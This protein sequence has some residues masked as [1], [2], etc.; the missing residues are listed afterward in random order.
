VRLIGVIDLKKGEAVH[1]RGG[2]RDTYAPVS[3]AAGTIVNGNAVTLARVY[4]DT[5][6]L[7]EIYVADLDAIETAAPPHDVVGDVAVLG[8]HVMLDA[9]V[10]T[11]ADI[12]RAGVAATA[13][14]VVGLETLES[15]DVLRKISQAEA[16][17]S[18]AFSLDLRNGRPVSS[19]SDIGRQSA[20]DVCRR[21][22]AA[23]VS[24]IIVLEL[25]RV[26][27]VAG[28]DVELLGRIRTA[29][30]AASILAG[31]GVRDLSDLRQLA[32]VGCDGAL[33]ATALHNG[34]LTPEDVG[35]A[36]RL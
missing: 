21:V 36:S 6:G 5:L 12:P 9:G 15:F 11:T 19:V 29:I 25:A 7:Q 23:G 3:E 1:A 13:T 2:L 30:P 16:G 34:R 27:R 31:G 28:P 4:R 32:K 24:T 26:G 35:A 10:R 22:V 8:T 20:E 18:V 14:I 33:V 17:R